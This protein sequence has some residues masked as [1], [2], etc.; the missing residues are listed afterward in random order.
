MGR[1]DI[2]TVKIHFIPNLNASAVQDT[3]WFQ[4]KTKRGG[5]KWMKEKNGQ[6]ER[7]NFASKHQNLL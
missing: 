4:N 2:I 3:N 6:E 5:M 1:N 7:K